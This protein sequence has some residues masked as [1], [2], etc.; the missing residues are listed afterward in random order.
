[1]TVNFL[2]VE[3]CILTRS[4]CSRRLYSVSQST[5]PPLFS[6]EG[7]DLNASCKGIYEVI[8]YVE[9]G[10]VLSFPVCALNYGVTAHNVR[11]FNGNPYFFT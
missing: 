9:F 7:L 2:N 10:G 8:D 4:R 11:I 6:R 3:H 5:R 1:M